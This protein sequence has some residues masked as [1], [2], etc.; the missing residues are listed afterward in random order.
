MQR[1]KRVT[2]IAAALAAVLAGASGAQAQDS[3]GGYIGASIGQTDIDANGFDSA[4][5]YRIFGGYMFTPMWGVEGGYIDAGDF[6]GK[7]AFANASIEG[8]GFYT[9]GVGRYAL[10]DSVALNGK[11]GV[12][13][14]DFDGKVNGNTTASD[15]S[16]SLL[17]GFGAD[18]Y[19]TPTMAVG[20]EYNLVTDV[21]ES[22][23]DAIW[24]NFRFD[25]TG[26]Y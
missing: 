22:D 16:A 7:G 14:A 21:D 5:G 10:T 25:M 15:D 2:A 24:L 9:A 3:I 19:F 11:V 4:T 20:A 13:F 23:V 18:W 1:N 26:A 17:L 6:D 12:M 8:S